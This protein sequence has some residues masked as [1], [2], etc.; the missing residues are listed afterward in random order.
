MTTDI[1]LWLDFM[2]KES[3]LTYEGHHFKGQ[4]EVKLR[5]AKGSCVLTVNLAAN[6]ASR[7]GGNLP[8]GVG[9]ADGL[10]EEAM[11]QLASLSG[12]LLV[13]KLPALPKT[14]CPDATVHPSTGC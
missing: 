5:L 9:P 11:L 10:H 7:R 8:A 2:C 13:A 12:L 6:A 4:G 3:T 14:D 1:N